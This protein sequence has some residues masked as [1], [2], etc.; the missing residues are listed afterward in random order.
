MS[1]S[2]NI[3]RRVSIE[4]RGLSVSLLNK[5]IDKV[6]R[7]EIHFDGAH[8]QSHHGSDG[9]YVSLVDPGG[10]SG[11]LSWSFPGEL[12]GT[13]GVT[14]TISVDEV[15]LGVN[16]AS[17]AET[18]VTCSGTVGTKHY[19]FAYGTLNPLTIAISP[20]TT[21]TFPVHTVNQWRRALYEVYVSLGSVVVTRI[22]HL[23]LIDLTGFYAP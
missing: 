18:V 6:N 21:Q 2:D 9:V 17:S 11:G 7:S 23:G 12:T 22:I 13:S 14:A 8:F 10:G 1:I 3:I 20:V 5:L 16:H 4:E 15:V 19:I